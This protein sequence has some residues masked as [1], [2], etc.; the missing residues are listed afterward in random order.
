[1]Q[2]F[3]EFR[4]LTMKTTIDYI[5]EAMQQLDLQND[6][7]LAKK[8]NLGSGTITNYRKG[9]R[10][11][12]DYTAAKIAELLRIPAIEV[13][14]AANQERE[15]DEKK[16]EFWKKI[17]AT[18]MIIAL[19]TTNNNQIIKIPHNRI[20]IMRNRRENKGKYRHKKRHRPA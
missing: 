17:R 8:L 4:G 12:D 3:F 18:C 16:K 2:A 13:I 19:T 6:F 9:K 5:N 11:V 15:Q 10:I 7:A 14:A 20:Y 1:M